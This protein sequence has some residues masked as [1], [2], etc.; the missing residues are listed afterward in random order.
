MRDE[1]GQQ[2]RDYDEYQAVR[3]QSRRTDTSET[4]KAVPQVTT[5]ADL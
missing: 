1:R 2:S 3:E 4:P 5:V